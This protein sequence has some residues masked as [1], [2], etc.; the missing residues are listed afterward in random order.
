MLSIKP[1]K[2]FKTL[3]R[4]FLSHPLQSALEVV[5]RFFNHEDPLKKKTETHSV[6]LK[7]STRTTNHTLYPINPHQNKYCD[8]QE[9]FQRYW[10]SW[11]AQYGETLNDHYSKRMTSLFWMVFQKLENSCFEHYEGLFDAVFNSGS[12]LQFLM[13]NYLSKW[14]YFQ[15]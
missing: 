12:T 8:V 6:E 5:H 10:A 13:D 7:E 11:K 4:R 9:R 3:Q 2:K 14:N 1:K 15:N